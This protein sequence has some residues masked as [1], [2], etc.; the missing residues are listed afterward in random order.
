ML[1]QLLSSCISCQF[2]NPRVRRTCARCGSALSLNATAMGPAHTPLIGQAA[3]AETLH[4]NIDRAFS[5]GSPTVVY[6]AGEAGSGKTRLLD[7]AAEFGARAAADVVLLQASARLTTG[8]NPYEPF[9][10]MLL[11]RLGITPDMPGI[12]ARGHMSTIVSQALSTK[13]AVTVAETTHLLGHIAGIEFPDSPFLAPLAERPHE[14]RRRAMAALRQFLEGDVQRQPILVLIDDADAMEESAWMTVRSLFAV[15]GHIA[16]VLTGNGESASKAMGVGPGSQ[17]E[18]VTVE[19]M[20]D[21]DVGA[22]LFVLLPNLDAAP[23]PLV[24]ALQHRSQGNPGVLTA[25]VPSLVEHGLFREREGVLSADLSKLAN[26]RFPITLDD[27]IAARLARLDD[28]E[29]AT[30][31]R[32]AIVGPVFWDA[33][34]VSVMRW[35]SGVTCA[36]G[37]ADAVLACSDESDRNFVESIFAGLLAKSFLVPAPAA[38]LPGAQAYAFQVPRMRDVL[39]AAQDENTKV[40]RHTAVAGWL[41]VTAEVRR[42]GI[43]ALIA[44]HLEEAGWLHRAGRAYFEAAAY[45]RARLHT[46]AALHFIEKAIPLIPDED[47]VRRIDAMHERG[48]LLATLGRYDEAITTFA[49]MLAHAHRIG[50]RA[51]AAAALNR[52]GRVHRERGEEDRAEQVLTRALD[53]FRSAGDLRGVAATLDDLAQAVRLRGR[54]AKALPLALEALEIRRAH[55]DKRGEAVSLSTLGSIEFS[56]GRIEAAELYYSESLAIRES[57][58]DRLGVM[59]CHNALAALAYE[60]GNA[61]AAVTAWKAALG[62]AREIGA[63]RELCF[64]LNNLG[65]ALLMLGETI[66]ASM[67]LDEAHRLAE[68]LGDKRALA[69][70]TRNRGVVAL[71]N[72]DTGANTLFEEALRIAEDFGGREAIAHALRAIAQARGQSGGHIGGDTD[73]RAERE[74][75]ASIELFRVLGNEREVARSIAA[76][77]HHLAEREQ[78]TRATE[79]L[80]EARGMMERLGLMGLEQVDATLRVLNASH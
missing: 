78:N 56:R 1:A 65:E 73:G 58:G 50:A 12:A 39:Y 13:D 27:A 48:S 76:L 10:S 28:N 69:E 24:S 68:S 40:Q 77:G 5:L 79:R 36:Q 31:E 44:P 37:K 30:L 11:E 60:S 57:V 55:G 20:T 23:E 35:E 2:T 66:E 22:M 15:D 54:P 74:F 18:V 59:Q 47:V 51:K 62:P 45:E 29:R 8:G 53:L 17:A 38:A 32:A 26:D 72:G 42:E 3:A 75:I 7:H 19:P 9:A 33:A 61:Q 52:I 80:T 46:H 43:A 14:L 70:I 71:R 16:F 4:A 63:R 49:D 41:A 64:M 6:I 34:V 25:L 67:R 21:A